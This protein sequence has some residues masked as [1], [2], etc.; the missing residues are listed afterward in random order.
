MGDVVGGGEGG[1]GFEGGC[2]ESRSFGSV[3]GVGRGGGDE[4][5]CL[6]CGLGGGC[7]VWF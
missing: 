2:V 3:V 7:R 1:V 4:Q 5:A 6:L